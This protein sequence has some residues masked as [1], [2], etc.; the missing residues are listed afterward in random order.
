CKVLNKAPI[1][2]AIALPVVVIA[3]L[4]RLVLILYNS[5]GAMNLVDRRFLSNFALLFRKFLE[6]G[7]SPVSRRNH[8]LG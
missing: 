1:V 2:E 3:R 8:H 4:F 5:S 7:I 6:S